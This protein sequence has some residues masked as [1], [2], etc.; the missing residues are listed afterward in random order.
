MSRRSWR[1]RIVKNHPYVYRERPLV[2]LDLRIDEEEFYLHDL[3][4]CYGQLD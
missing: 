1:Y 3:I 2:D 4:N